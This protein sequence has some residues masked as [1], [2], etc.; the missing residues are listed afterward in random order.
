MS[1]FWQK[2]RAGFTLVELVIAIVV[3]GIAASGVLLVMNYTTAHSADPMIQHQAVAIAEAYLE[4]VLL[5]PYSDPDAVPSVEANRALYDDLDDY[6]FTDVGARDPSG[7]AIAGLGAYTVTVA[8]TADTL[9]TVAA[10]RVDVTVTH[11]S[12]IDMTLTGYRTNY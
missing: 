7:A 8:V 12:G 4:E 3:I 1:R 10:K 5:Q 11:P 9:N 6:N 2:R